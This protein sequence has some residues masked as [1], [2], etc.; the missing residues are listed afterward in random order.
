[1]SSSPQLATRFGPLE[2]EVLEALWKRGTPSSVRDILPGFPGVAYTTLMTTMDRL[3][4]KG[5]LSRQKVSRAFVYEPRFSEQE[6]VLDIAARAFD[7]L[8]PSGR[9]EA[10]P[11]LMRFVEVIAERDH[12][13]LD[14]LD[15]LI[16]RRLQSLREKPG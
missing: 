5:I 16:R 3:F 10:T 6:Q 4:Q 2:I 13:L 12:A 8:L 7:V 11:I 9:D 14:D 1:M 15:E